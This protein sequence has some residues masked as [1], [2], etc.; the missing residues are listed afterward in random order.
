[1]KNLGICEITGC[2]NRA[3]YSLNRQV[4]NKKVWTNV[5][6]KH[7]WEIGNENY[8]RAIAKEAKVTK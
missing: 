1:M 6:R 2:L 8:K 7:E 3:N 4:G 5:C